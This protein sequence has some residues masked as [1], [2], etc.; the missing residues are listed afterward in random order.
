M[1]EPPHVREVRCLL[2]W[3]ADW[4][5]NWLVDRLRAILRLYEAEAN[6]T[7]GQVLADVAAEQDCS[8]G[9]V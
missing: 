4:N 2:A 6:G 1:E 5:M 9:D 7:I 8:G 3:A